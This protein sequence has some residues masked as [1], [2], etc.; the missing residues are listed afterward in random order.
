MV[1]SE[2]GGLSAEAIA[3]A[4]HHAAIPM[5]GLGTSLNV[6][7]AVGVILL[8][9]ERQRAAAGLYAASRLTADER[10]R[11]LFEWSYPEIAERC[12]ELGRPYP[13]LTE[14]GMLVSNPLLDVPQRA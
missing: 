1:G 4:D 13:G 10:A 9:A 6:S 7:V 8:E 5:Q 11:T 3:A 2:L 12:R 14:D